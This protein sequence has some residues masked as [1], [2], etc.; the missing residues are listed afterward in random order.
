MKLS[1]TLKNTGARDGDEVAQVYFRHVN[2]A[3]PSTLLSSNPAEGGQPSWRSAVL[4][5]SIWSGVGGVNV[6]VKSRR[7]GFVTGTRQKNNML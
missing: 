3:P 7:S 5:V 4:L 2:S 6:T 1:F